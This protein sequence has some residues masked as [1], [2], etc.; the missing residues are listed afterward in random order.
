MTQLKGK[1]AL[2]VG[3]S[4]GVG[5]AT[6]LALLSEGVHVTAVARGADG[7]R[8]LEAE[9]R[10]ERLTTF[11]GDATDPALA[12]RLVRELRPDL[13]V[14]A[15]GVTPS[16]GHVHELDWESFSE[17]WNVDL[18]ASFQFT[19]QALGLPLAPGSSVILLSSGAAIGGS[20]LSGGYAGA[21]RMQWW[22]ASYAQKVSDAKR[23]G[24][25][26]LAVLPRQLLLG[27][28]IGARASAFYGKLDGTSAEAFMQRYDIPLDAS[29]VASAIVTALDG[30][31]PAGINAIAVTGAGIEP[32]A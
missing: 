7:L 9:A 19:K 13:V 32:L 17:A 30:G 29:K 22:L 26:T 11:R 18:R 28:A 31:V 6:V 25:R 3:G 15:L 10:D 1:R 24:I 8:A 20:P 23:L 27:T 5:K 21:K 16:M 2:V 4:S 12:E 14:L